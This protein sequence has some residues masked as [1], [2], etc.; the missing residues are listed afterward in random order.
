[1]YLDGVARRTK[2]TLYRLIEAM[3]STHST[4][5]KYLIQGIVPKFLGDMDRAQ[6]LRKSL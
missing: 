3:Q 6:A 2:S 1:V 4:D 5:I